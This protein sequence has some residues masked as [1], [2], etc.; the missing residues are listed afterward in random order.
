MTTLLEETQQS[1][2]KASVLSLSFSLENL[3]LRE[4]NSIL[5]EV[6]G[7]KLVYQE[8]IMNLSGGLVLRRRGK[9]LPF[10]FRKRHRKVILEVFFMAVF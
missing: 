2:K 4:R 9:S 6:E 5:G 10:F 1:R 8:V 3:V 7:Y